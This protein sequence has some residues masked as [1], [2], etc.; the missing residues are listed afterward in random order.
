MQPAKLAA[1]VFGAAL[2]VGGVYAV[3]LNTNAHPSVLQ[4]DTLGPQPG[5]TAYDYA[6]RAQAS[7]RDAGSERAFA[8]VSFAEPRN[9]AHAAAAVTAAPRVGAL[10][11]ADAPSKAIPEPAP[12]ENRADVFARE[13]D[14]MVAV[15]EENGVALDADAIVAVVVHAP[16]DVLREI[17]RAPDVAAVEVLP[18]DAVW[19]AFGITPIR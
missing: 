11:L 17:A 4:G 10:V 7:L 6:A 16:G 1:A 15:G 2:V 12:G 19:G 13:A 8:L 5:E 9:P 14:R 3:G 18:P